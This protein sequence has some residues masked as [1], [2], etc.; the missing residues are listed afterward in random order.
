[1]ILFFAPWC[2]HCNHLKSGPD[3]A[4][5]KLKQKHG[6]KVKFEEVNGDEKPDVATQFGVKSFPTILKLKKDKVEEIVGD[7]SLEVLEEFVYSE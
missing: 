3:S 4:W 7:R 2:S 5:E 6:H 1:M